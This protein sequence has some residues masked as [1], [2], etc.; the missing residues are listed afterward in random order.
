MNRNILPNCL[1]K[2]KLD[3]MANNTVQQPIQTAIRNSNGLVLCS[4][5]AQMY[6]NCG[7][8]FFVLL[9]LKKK[10]K[11]TGGELNRKK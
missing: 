5:K 2:Q 4:F 11:I 9:Y 10:K 7:W 8:A 1:Q 6:H 3:C